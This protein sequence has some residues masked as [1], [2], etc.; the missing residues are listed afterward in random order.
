LLAF[1]FVATAN[2]P[3][4]PGS[5]R[6]LDEIVPRASSFVSGD[7]VAAAWRISSQGNEEIFDMFDHYLSIEDASASQ[8]GMRVIIILRYLFRTDDGFTVN[9]GRQLPVARGVE[10]LPDYPLL[11][12]DGIPL[13]LADDFEVA[14]KPTSVNTMLKHYRNVAVRRKPLAPDL[15][16]NADIICQKALTALRDKDV[17][18]TI[19]LVALFN[20]QTT[21]RTAIR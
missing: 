1:P 19:L 7:L 20:K 13:L 2:E 4:F 10:S 16:A 6:A 14:G 15:G 3:K 8:R 11:I 5:L 18:N 21:R 17:G 9:L 12:I